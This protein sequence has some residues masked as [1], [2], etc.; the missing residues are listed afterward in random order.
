MEN[1][2]LLS[3]FSVA[4]ARRTR[5]RRVSGIVNSFWMLRHAANVF[6]V[7][8]ISYNEIRS[9]ITTRVAAGNGGAGAGNVVAQVRERKG[10][11]D[12]YNSHP[13]RDTEFNSFPPIATVSR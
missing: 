4:T 13:Y 6:Y 10:M 1:D 5:M 7:L 9:K 8:K 2:K 12:I 3:R 11:L